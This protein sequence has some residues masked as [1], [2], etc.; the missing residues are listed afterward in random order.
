MGIIRAFDIKSQKEMKPLK[1]EKEIG[2]NNKVTSLDVSADGGFLLAGY[3]GGQVALW[4]LVD[5]KL[6]KFI[7]DLHQSE[8]T[9]ARIYHIDESGSLYALTAED[10]GK[11]QFVKFHKKNFLG[12][13]ASEAQFLFKA[14]LTGT[15]SLAIQRK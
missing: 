5:Y 9:N 2:Q 10:T 8:I 6:V 14:R 12:G 13:Y 15:T 3:K 11:V 4:D 1:D 7:G